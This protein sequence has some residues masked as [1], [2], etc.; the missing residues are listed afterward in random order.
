MKRSFTRTVAG[1]AIFASLAV[2]FQNCGPAKVSTDGV[3]VA[4]NAD[5][6]SNSGGQEPSGSNPP[7]SS[8]PQPTTTPVPGSTPAPTPASTPVATPTPVQGPALK[9]STTM[10]NFGTVN[11]PD[12]SASKVVVLT[13]IG[14]AS[15]M[16]NSKVVIGS[17]FALDFFGN[18]LCGTSLA[19]GASCNISAYYT[20]FNF[21]RTTGVIQIIT[22]AP[23]SPL[24]IQLEGNSPF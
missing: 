11:F 15:V 2:L 22:N 10:L 14:N 19:V 5:L 13:N 4:G 9:A 16:I 12:R 24:V 23:N 3:E 17:D 8:T 1:A 6:G 7:P 21:G 20:P 18:G